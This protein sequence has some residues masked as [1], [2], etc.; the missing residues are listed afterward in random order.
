MTRWLRSRPKR[1]VQNVVAGLT[2]A[3]AI[4]LWA[5]PAS[6]ER[7]L[8]NSDCCQLPEPV[9]Q[10]PTPTPDRNQRNSAHPGTKWVVCC[11]PA[12]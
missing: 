8:P 1:S 12:G 10:A 3:I 6:A 9:T 4:G 7:L 5:A 2:V 11:D